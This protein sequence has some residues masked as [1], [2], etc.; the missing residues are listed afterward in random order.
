MPPTEFR[1]VDDAGNPRPA[2]EIGELIVSNPGREREYFNDPEATASTWR[3]GW[4]HSGDL[5]YLDEDGFLYI[6]GRQKDVIIRGG[7]NIYAT[8]VEA[9]LY[10]HPAV[11]EAAVAGVPH[12][13]LGEDVGAWIVLAPGAAATAEELKAFC[14]ERLSDYKVPRRITFVDELPRNATGKVLKRDLPGC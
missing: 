6:V 3:D 12:T 4:L 8:D 1:I 14:A 5:A 11:Q 2:R 10:E 9:V 13:V 7:N